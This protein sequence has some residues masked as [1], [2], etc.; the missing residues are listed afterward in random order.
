MKEI[1]MM[2]QENHIPTFKKDYELALINNKEKFNSYG[3]EWTINNAKH[4]LKY[5]DSR[6]LVETIGD[7]TY[8]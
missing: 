2:I 8:C 6:P 7:D 3:R 1:Y 5:V 4:V